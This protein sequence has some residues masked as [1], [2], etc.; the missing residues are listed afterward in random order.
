MVR[1]RALEGAPPPAVDNKR[2]RPA[3]CGL[4][5]WEARAAPPQPL[6]SAF[7]R[8]KS[9]RRDARAATLAAA[10]ERD[11][12]IPKGKAELS[13]C[14]PPVLNLFARANNGVGDHIRRW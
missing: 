7:V 12:A 9:N 1:G 3:A 5:R 4:R 2:A 8:R 6:R 10:R 11:A 14:R 13:L